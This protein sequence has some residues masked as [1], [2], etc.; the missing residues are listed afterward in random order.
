MQSDKSSGSVK[1]AVSEAPG[2]DTTF[3]NKQTD[4]LSTLSL[5]DQ[6]QDIDAYMAGQGEDLTLTAIPGT[7]QFQ[8]T[9]A[10]QGMSPVEKLA[11]VEREKQQRMEIGETWFLISC[12]WWKRWRKA[13]TGEEDKEGA[14]TEQELIPV[15]NS[16]L[17]DAGGSLKQ[18]LLEGED[19]QYVPQHVWHFFTTWLV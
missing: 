4:Q 19:V 2:M 14:V 18:G 13:C 17:I 3:P 15:D 9:D 5:A 1:R 8:G 7:Q 6:T 12:A 11:L 16:A 10:A